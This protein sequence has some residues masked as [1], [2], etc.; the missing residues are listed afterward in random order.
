MSENPK[1]IAAL[2]KK[3]GLVSKTVGHIE[4]GSA[5]PGGQIS[6]KFQK[7]D[8]VLPRLR[9]ACIEHGLWVIPSVHTIE[10]IET[11]NKNG[12]VMA[13]W[14]LGLEFTII[15]CETGA[16]LKAQWVG[17][18]ADSGDKGAQ[19]AA[20]SGTK[21]WLLKTFMIPSAEVDD[22]DGTTVER[23]KAPP[24]PVPANEEVRPIDKAMLKLGLNTKDCQKRVQD[25]MAADSKLSQKKATE[26]V[27]AEII[28][29]ANL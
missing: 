27:V 8:D 19:K 14:N 1:D 5:G 11:T 10:K 9:D 12:T 6:Y 26:Q 2:A 7:W 15:D 20:T 21:Y 4:K 25:A 23:G 17:E 3:I 18:S 13:D 28:A 16:Q 22:N 24:K 29:E